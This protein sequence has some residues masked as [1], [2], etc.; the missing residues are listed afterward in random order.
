M[1]NMIR[2]RN[3]IKQTVTLEPLDHFDEPN[4]RR[5]L[6]ELIALLKEKKDWDMLPFFLRELRLSGRKIPIAMVERLVRRAAETGF[7]GT[8]IEIFRHTDVAGLRIEDA[9]VAMEVMLGI[10]RKATEAEWV[11]HDLERAAQNAETALRMMLETQHGPSDQAVSPGKEPQ[12]VGVPLALVGARVV[13][14][15]NGRDEEG[16]VRE[17]AR[18]WVECF[19]E[20]EID[21]DRGSP[22]EGNV[23]LTEWAPS[24]LGVSLAL[25]ILK[26]E[27]G[28]TDVLSG[29]QK[30]TLEPLIR[31]ALDVAKEEG[32]KAEERRGVRL[33][34][35]LSSIL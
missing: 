10:V 19:G 11:E 22:A 24:W 32:A 31:K 28:L 7:V 35:N 18:R 4:T 20:R 26:K 5:S 16:K 17:Y 12:V 9:R 14:Y 25:K 30:K 21:V 13:K 8:L 1:S 34:N 6:R 3:P 23:A 15:K 33:Y 2:Y 27:P 29:I